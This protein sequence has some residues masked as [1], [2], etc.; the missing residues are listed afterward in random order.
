MRL[1]EMKIGGIYV[2]SDHPLRG[3]E[4]P[5]VVVLTRFRSPPGPRLEVKI[6]KPGTSYRGAIMAKKGALLRVEPKALRMSEDEFRILTVQLAD[7]R[8]RGRE[9]AVELRER[10]K[11]LPELVGARPRQFSTTVYPGRALEEIRVHLNI[12]LNA[13]QAE[14]LFS[15]LED[16]GEG[17][18]ES[19]ALVELLGEGTTSGAS[20][21]PT[22]E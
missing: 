6:L 3:R 10:A 17:E 9:K 13:A 22:Q 1:S 21:L 19:S 16:R 7:R 20:V 2:I 15:L 18:G 8:E 4:R 5:C 14:K 11:H 12:Q